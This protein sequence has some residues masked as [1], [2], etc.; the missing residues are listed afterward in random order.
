VLVFR[1]EFTIVFFK[2]RIFLSVS[3]IS[4]N[5]CLHSCYLFFLSLEYSHYSLDINIFTI[6][7]IVTFFIQVINFRHTIAGTYRILNTEPFTQQTNYIYSKISEN[8]G[9]LFTYL[10][11]HFGMHTACT[12]FIDVQ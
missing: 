3:L 2:S 7:E 1:S 12:S 6:S 9:K 11:V 4:N 8:L 5:L 10:A